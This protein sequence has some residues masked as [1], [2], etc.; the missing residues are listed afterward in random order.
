MQSFSH[1]IY[2][3]RFGESGALIQHGRVFA[4]S[5]EQK[6]LVLGG[7][8]CIW[9]E[10]VDATNLISRTWPRASAV[11]ERLWSPATLVNPDAAAA[12]FEEHRCR[13]LRRGLHA[14]PQNGPGFCECDH[15]V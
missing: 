13:M 8:A 12:R 4:G 9:G 3:T 14:E 7:E 2:M 1:S 15:L 11:A 5:P 6:A 10:W